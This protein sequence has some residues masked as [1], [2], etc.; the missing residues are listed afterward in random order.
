[1]S[2]ALDDVLAALPAG[3]DSNAV[4]EAVQRIGAA[5]VAAAL[6]AKLS[7]SGVLEEISG[8]AQLDRYLSE[9]EAEEL[10]VSKLQDRTLVDRIEDDLALAAPA[11]SDAASPLMTWAIPLL[12]ALAGPLA[13][14]LSFG[15]SVAVKVALAVFVAWSKR[16]LA[17][18][19]Q[20]GS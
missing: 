9:L 19:A 20:K 12:S 7:P 16:R 4:A 18:A 15:M 8:N 13:P 10:A 11:I 1:M 6:V 2:T 3:A 17:A 5:P 14:L